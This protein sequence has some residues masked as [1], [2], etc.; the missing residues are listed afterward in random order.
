MVTAKID[1]ILDTYT[2]EE[3]LELNDLTEADV[4]Q[5][6]VDAGHVEV[7]PLPVDCL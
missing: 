3:I 7:D 4:L 6:L 2:F 1:R 5:I